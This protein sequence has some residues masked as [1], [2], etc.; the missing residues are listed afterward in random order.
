MQGRR[1]AIY[2]WSAAPPGTMSPCPT[3]PNR[4]QDTSQELLAVPLRW[5][6]TEHWR[7][8]ATA[9]RV[10]REIAFTD[11]DDPWGYVFSTTEADTDQL[12]LVSHLDVGRHTISVG[13]DWRDD[14]VTVTD[15]YGV[16]MDDVNE[17]A[18]GVFVQ[19]HWQVSHEI[20][21]LAGVRWE[22]T[23]SWG[24][25]TTGRLDVGWRVSDTVELRGGVGQAFR[26]PALGELYGSFGGNPD[27]E[28]ESSTSAEIGA[29]YT[30]ATGN[31]GGS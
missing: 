12:R 20:R 7:I 19:D 31:P 15:P 2:T 6:L 18:L 9:S 16:S 3:I 10:A 30:P 1:G 22:D 8:E 29:V 24:S 17:D 25:E 14:S 21:V 13:A 11:P 27:L 28:P 23:D 5:S 4:R 26:A